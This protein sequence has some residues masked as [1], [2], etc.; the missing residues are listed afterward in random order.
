[1]YPKHFV[2]DDPEQWHSDREI[3]IQITE[4]CLSRW[5]A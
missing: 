3:F 2:N 4:Y 5:N 1:M